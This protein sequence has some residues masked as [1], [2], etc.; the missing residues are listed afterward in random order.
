MWALA[1]GC[2]NCA[3]SRFAIAFMHVQ[4]VMNWHPPHVLRTQRIAKLASYVLIAGLHSI[5]LLKWL[6]SENLQR[7]SLVTITSYWL[8]SI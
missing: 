8:W 3:L 4:S 6:M 2:V 5:L 7:P 1:Q